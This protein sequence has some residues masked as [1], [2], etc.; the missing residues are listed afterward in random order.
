MRNDELKQAG[1]VIELAL[2]YTIGFLVMVAGVCAT[3]LVWGL[4]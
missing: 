3:V 4:V 1:Q 2:R